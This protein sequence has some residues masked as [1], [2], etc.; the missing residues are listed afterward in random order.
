MPAHATVAL[1]TYTDSDFSYA[2]RAKFPD[3]SYYDF[4]G[5]RLQLMV[6]KFPEAAEVYLTLD[7]AVDGVGAGKSGIDLEQGDDGALS[8]FTIVIFRGDLQ[9]IP[10]GNY[11]HSLIVTPPD[12]LHYDFWRGPLTN[13]IGPT[14]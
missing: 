1:Q 9:R 4:T 14:R 6:R 13:S 2:F 5:C 12:D 8:I 11:V 3:D 10:A 7:S